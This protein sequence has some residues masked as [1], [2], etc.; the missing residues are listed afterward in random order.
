VSDGTPLSNG[1]QPKKIE[2]DEGVAPHLPIIW[3]MA[4]ENKSL[5]EIGQ[6]LMDKQLSTSKGLQWRRQSISK[7]LKNPF[8]KG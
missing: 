6:V 5:S 2:I 7:M 4:A 1:R 8:Y 3:E